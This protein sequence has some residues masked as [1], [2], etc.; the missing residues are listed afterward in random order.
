MII[1]NNEMRFNR[2][3]GKWRKMAEN[4]ALENFSSYWI[5]MV[6]IWLKIQKYQPEELSWKGKE[7]L[8]RRDIVGKGE[9][10]QKEKRGCTE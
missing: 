10:R 6:L 2:N 7:Y 1:N 9:E 3:G 4:G 5:L 8:R